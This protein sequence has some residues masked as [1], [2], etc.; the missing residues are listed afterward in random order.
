[1]NNHIF[2]IRDSYFLILA[3]FLIY[4]LP[5]G[6]R[7]LGIPD[8]MRYAEIPREML[9]NGDWIVPT[10]NGVFYFEKPILG[11]WLS[12]ISIAIFGENEFAVRFPFSLLSGL[13]TLLIFYFVQKVVDRRTAIIASIVQL[14]TM[15]VYFVGT[16]AVLDSLLAFALC[17]VF[18]FYYLANQ[19]ENATQRMSYLA[20]SGVFCGLS[21]L[22]KGFLAFA[23]PT[24][25]NGA[26]L[27]FQRRYLDLLRHAVVPIVAAGIVV[28]PWAIAVH[29]R[30]PDFW[31]YFFWI[32]HVKRFSGDDAQHS[33][34]I[35]TYLAA[36]PLLGFPWTLLVINGVKKLRLQAQHRTLIAYLAIWFVLPFLFFSIA[37]GKLLTYLLPIFPAFSIL[38][39]LAIEKSGQSTENEKTNRWRGETFGFIF[40]FVIVVAMVSVHLTSDNRMLFASNEQVKFAF[41]A[42]SLL[43]G[44]FMLWRSTLSTTSL[45]RSLWIGATLLPVFF[46]W[47]S[48]VGLPREIANRKSPSEFLAAQSQYISHDVILMSDDSLFHSASWVYKRDDIYML[49]SGELE[50]GLTYDDDKKRNLENASLTTFMDS[51]SPGQNFAIFYLGTKPLSKLENLSPTLKKMHE[52]HIGRFNF[53]YL[54]KL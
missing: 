23:L 9:V 17:G 21:F 6:L 4:I 31:H 54:R 22:A 29:Q 42:A 26:F 14:S 47:A 48:F 18:V 16:Y 43:S 20:I 25:V 50:Y 53:V 5:L 51:F 49:Y 45:S 40:L 8:E 2:G 41:L 32:E 44:G 46:Y 27:L 12:A 28:A 36:F 7:P 38:T 19:A 33:Q 39:A 3:Y 35:W 34:P 24:I 1:M 15:E 11:Y 52:S 30:A 10:L 37:K 13:T